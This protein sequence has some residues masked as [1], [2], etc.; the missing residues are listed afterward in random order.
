MITPKEIEQKAANVYARFLKAWARGRLESEFFPVRIP[1]NLAPYKDNLAATA[2]AVE[3]LKSHSK[4]VRGWGY[5]LDLSERRDTSLGRNRYPN[6]I[7]VDTLDDLLRLAGKK[8]EFEAA[9]VVFQRVS[10]SFPKL[11]DWAKAS[12]S[13]LHRHADYIEDLIKVATYF[14]E[15]PWPDCYARQISVNVDTKFVERHQRIL[16]QWLDKLLPASAIDVNESRFVRRFGLRD[17]E[18]HRG[19]RLLDPSLKHDVGLPF[20]EMSLPSWELQNLR[21]V[22]T[23]VFVVEN[24]L[25]LVTLPPIQ[26]ALAIRGEG[27][28]VTRL[29]K[30]PW[31]ESSE[32]YYWGDIDV[33]GFL[34][35]SAM[36][37]LFPQT[38]SILMDVATL[39]AHKEAQVSGNDNPTPVPSNLTSEE[40]RAF[41]LC[42]ASNLRLEQEKISQ[43]YV[44]EFIFSC[45]LSR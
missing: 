6:S 27:R 16:H 17:A 9:Q 35:L 20:D 18:Q 40:T 34:I 19:I 24:R 10:E 29:E 32:I 33:D 13:S 5:R 1:S 12:V 43:S 44:N 36:R 45:F 41:S 38:K 11:Q 15:N 37:N 7:Y 4:Q 30:L 3:S 25:N 28:A 21:V 39:G 2:A 8:G 31:L 22:N 26:R 14:V 23:R 42:S